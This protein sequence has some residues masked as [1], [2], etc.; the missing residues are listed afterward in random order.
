MLSPLRNEIAH[1]IVIL[2]FRADFYNRLTDVDH[3]RKLY[4]LIRK[5]EVAVFPMNRDEMR[6]AIQSPLEILT[7]PVTFAPRTC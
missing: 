1:L 7:E 5:H 6:E 4:Q 2:T 3:Y